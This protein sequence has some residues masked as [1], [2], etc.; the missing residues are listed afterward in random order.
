MYY[1]FFHVQC[2]AFSE[3]SD[4]ERKL[5]HVRSGSVM[6]VWTEISRRT[7]GDQKILLGTDD[8][9]SDLPSRHCAIYFYC[10]SCTLK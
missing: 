8:L 4:C 3:M 6:S 2:K 5:S 1:T 10:D 7:L 9:L